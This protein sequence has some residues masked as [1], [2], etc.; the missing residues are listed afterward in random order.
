MTSI[1]NNNK[2]KNIWNNEEEGKK[3]R[4]KM[5]GKEGAEGKISDCIFQSTS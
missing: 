2:K 1:N 5:R 4:E 3:K